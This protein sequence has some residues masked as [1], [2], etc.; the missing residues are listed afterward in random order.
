MHLIPVPKH[1]E[2]GDGACA[3]VAGFD[4]HSIDPTLQPMCRLLVGESSPQGIAV[5]AR[6][7]EPALPAALPHRV[8]IA[9]QAY[10]L[11]IRQG[12]VC[13]E[14]AGV[15]GWRN[16]L[17]TLAQLYRQSG[18]TLPYLT[19]EDHPDVP[20]RGVML[21]VSR[22]KI[23]TMAKLKEVVRLLSAYKLNV[24]QLYMEDCY[25]LEGHADLGLLNGWFDKKRIQTLDRYCSSYGIELQPNIQSLSHVHGLVR[26]P[27]RQSL[28]EGPALFSFAAGN[29]EVYRLLDDIYGEVLPWFSSKT[30]NL[31]LDEAFD[32]GTGY[33]KDEVTLHGARSVFARH[34]NAVAD[35]ARKHGARR[36]CMWGDCLNQYHGL[37]Q[38]V[39]PDV[40]FIDWNYNPSDDFP[41][42]R[43]HDSAGR[44]FW[45]ASGTSSWNALFPRTGNAA[46]NIRTYARQACALGVEGFLVTNWG[47]YGHHQPISFGYYGFIQ[48]AEHAYN[49]GRTAPEALEQAIA[50]L[51][52]ADAAE[53]K[54]FDLLG[55][56]NEVPAVAN[57][58]KSQS[59]YAFFDDMFKGLSIV[60]DD[61]YPPLEQGA[62]QSLR[63]LALQALEALRESHARSRFHQE[64]EHAARC[65]EF[66]GRKGE[67]GLSIR[68]AFARSQVDQ[69]QILSWIIQLKIMYREFLAL[70]QEFTRLW[71]AEAVDVGREGALYLFDKASSRFAEAVMWLNGQRVALS[72][73]RSLDTM[74]ETY[75]CAEGYTT[76]WTQDCTNLWDRAYPWR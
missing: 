72:E 37:Q 40:F 30:V 28:A 15:A 53:H 26:N 21:D 35:L 1:I 24:L 2:Y 68:D 63:L 65:L 61:R 29:P 18:L 51:F 13:I 45:A 75:R 48:A 54:A 52:F 32:L 39:A 20:Y 25:L 47:D 34:I 4:Y 9:P 50:A 27:G 6:K 55:R 5:V 17:A 19:I 69:D 8:L 67:F 49:G 11:S 22:G 16:A 57:A 60:G 38:E 59:F 56:T 64:L 43:N 66:T 76:L 71:D 31:D 41:S 46:H 73:G 58:F 23:P 12:E 36:I 14:A 70:R 74:M 33:S 44:P 10:R 62:F 3:V 42:L 7:Y